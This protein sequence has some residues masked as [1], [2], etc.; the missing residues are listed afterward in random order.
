MNYPFLDTIQFAPFK[1]KGL[2]LAFRLLQKNSQN[3][4]E[5]YGQ[6]Q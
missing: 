1:K 3:Y 5:P 6:L 4:S 2:E